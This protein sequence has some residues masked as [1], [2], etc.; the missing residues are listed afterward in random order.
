MGKV[1]RN[2]CIFTAIA[3]LAALIA[4]AATAADGTHFT[5]SPQTPYAESFVAACEGQQ[6]FIDEIERQLNLTQKTLDTIDSAAD[7]DT[8]H[9]L[10]FESA[11]IDG[12]IPAAIGELT[13]L[14]HLFLANNK[15]GGEIPASLFALPLLENVD[16]SGNQYSGAMPDGFGAMSSLKV[17]NVKNNAYTGNI[18]ASILNST[19]IEV[20][21]LMNNKL[22]GGIPSGISAMTA[23]TY[24]NLSGND[25]G[26]EMPDFSHNVNLVALSL[27]NCNLSGIIPD[28]IYTLTKL[29]ILDLSGN[30]L[31]GEISADI[32]N[33]SELQYLALDGNKLR[34]TLPDVFANMP[35]AEI[36]IENNF[37]RGMLPE[38]IANKD[39]KVYAQNNYMTGEAMKTI[40]SGD[41]NFVD[42]GTG[43]QYR[44]AA[45][46]TKLQISEEG[47]VNL[48]T[49]L[50]NHGSPNKPLLRPD[51]YTVTADETKVD[52][53][54]DN[55]GF[56]VRALGEIPL[57][58]NFR[59]TICIK[60][61]DG[62]DYSTVEIVAT[63]EKVA[64]P[65]GGASDSTAAPYH[66]RYVNGYADGGFHPEDNITREE[67]AK[68]LVDA[69][70]K[71]RTD[72]EE[73]TYPDVS[74]SRWSFEWIET[75][76][77]EGYVR[78]HSDG[79]FCPDDPVTRAELA[80]IL[81]RI[82]EKEA[83]FIKD[84]KIT[85]SDVDRNMWY[86]SYIDRAVRYG[87]INGYEGGTFRPEQY[88]T[89]AEAVVMT[90]R[91]LARNYKT[92]SE[93]QNE[94]CPFNDVAENY[95]A[96]GDIMEASIS[97][98]H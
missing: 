61:N 68:L 2:I 30:S 23:L 98:N 83:A 3:L 1:R 52:I 97:H 93:L 80:T 10:G 84:A 46:K 50:E 40:E 9:S 71:Q 73:E 56:Y 70:N 47:M 25:L 8:I 36:H 91:M 94:E 42:G 38:S 90:N 34:G 78:G 76:T 87:L 11:G 77:Q 5:P 75:A 88:I 82:S 20:L 53:T 62:S 57:S 89:R 19:S 58:E 32:A 79:L 37:L 45:T 4:P 21:N 28:S 13:K 69:M 74:Q 26:G 7:F 66:K 54:R 29:Q 59:V 12:H 14:R 48:Y 27:W 95:W 15:L 44:L 33:L 16:L 81:V 41:Y 43:V 18:P 86:A 60:D 24:L 17:L 39:A 22:T 6:W 65:T 55:N 51:E 67:V 92:A 35:I 49:L 63:T 64:A 96:Y 72:T 85:F 31:E